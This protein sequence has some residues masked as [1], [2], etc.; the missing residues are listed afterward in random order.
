MIYKTLLVLFLSIVKSKGNVLFY[1]PRHHT[2]TVAGVNFEENKQLEINVIHKK[3]EL[4][5]KSV[6]SYRSIQNS[7]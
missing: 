4:L 3:N 2:K 1:N 5:V 6:E 7:P